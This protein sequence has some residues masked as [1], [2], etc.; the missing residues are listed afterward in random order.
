MYCRRIVILSGE[1]GGHGSAKGLLQLTQESEG[2]TARLS[3][4][5][6][7]PVK[8]EYALVARIAS[9]VEHKTFSACE[10][11]ELCWRVSAPLGGVDRICALVGIAHS[12]KPVVYGSNSGL[13]LWES[14]L[15]RLLTE[16][17]R[18]QA[19]KVE[20]E[21]RAVQEAEQKRLVQAPVSDAPP[22]TTLQS[23][24]GELP[25][26]KPSPPQELREQACEQAAHAGYDD[27]AEAQEN[28]YPTSFLTYIEGGK[29]AAGLEN[30]RVTD[31][32]SYNVVYRPR[33]ARAHKAPSPQAQ[34]ESAACADEKAPP[35][36]D[37]IA[38]VIEALFSTCEPESDLNRNL[39][40]TAWVRV[41]YRKG[42]YYCVGRI[43]GDGKRPDYI[44]YAVPGE[45]ALNPPRQFEGLCKWLPRRADRPKGQGYWLMF[46][47]A[48]TGASVR[49]RERDG[50]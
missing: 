48:Q 25:P 29:R 3:L 23:E 9:A 45:Y 6:L 33:L 26:Q 27:E 38:S 28:Y 49:L 50:A 40:G 7:A 18:A 30:R 2:V 36:Y 37:K 24:D 43:G 4:Q 10:H 46:Q 15:P 44:G 11:A 13:P 19:K 42:T 31:W 8:L 47:D 35:Y 14:G 17:T 16:K 20:M 5:N 12:A 1:D 22:Q 32:D 39:P 41:T 34:R 21:K